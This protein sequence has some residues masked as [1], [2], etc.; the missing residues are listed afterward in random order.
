MQWLVDGFLGYLENWEAGV[1]ER[2]GFS[3]AQKSLMLL[4]R[5]TREG[6]KMTGALAL[7]YVY[8]CMQ[9]VMTTSHF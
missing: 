2:K 8:M 4:S 1:R 7:L 5:E 6:L 3:A 9:S